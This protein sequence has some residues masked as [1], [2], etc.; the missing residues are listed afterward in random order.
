MTIRYI[1]DIEPHLAGRL[2]S[3]LAQE[4]PGFNPVRSLCAMPH[5]NIEEAIFQGSDLDWL[6]ASMN[7]YLENKNDLHRIREDVTSLDAKAQYDLLVLATLH[8]DWGSD[9]S[10]RRLQTLDPGEWEKF[11]RKHLEAVHEFYRDP[12]RICTDPREA[13]VDLEQPVGSVPTM[14]DMV[15]EII[16][17]AEND[18]WE[19]EL[20]LLDDAPMH[21]DPTDR[22]EPLLDVHEVC[23]RIPGIH[24]VLNE[25]C[26][27]TK[28]AGRIS[29]ETSN[30]ARG[31]VSFLHD[32]MSPEDQ[33]S[34]R[35]MAL[36][37]LSQDE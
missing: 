2:T 13:L 30:V 22:D 12:D 37:R 9:A 24:Q 16:L 19:Q 26:Q 21:N 31:Y 28:L 20:N 18:V 6:P 34:L 32:H 11:R 36:E 1:V 14:A 5:D 27:W 7:E 10:R 29:A 25:A 35:E 8:G 15:R 4:L 33:I 3:L 23:R 17:E